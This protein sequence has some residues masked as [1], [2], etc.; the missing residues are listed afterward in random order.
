[1]IE[2]I[3][4]QILHMYE[5]N[6]NLTITTTKQD[7]KI[8]IN[9]FN[10]AILMMNCDKNLATENAFTVHSN[11]LKE[12]PEKRMHYKSP[13]GYINHALT[14]EKKTRLYSKVVDVA[15]LK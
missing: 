8:V 15:P 13:F 10:P 6:G 3:Y 12:I 14:L 5:H 1:M 7:I 4:M 9:F 2:I 11:Y